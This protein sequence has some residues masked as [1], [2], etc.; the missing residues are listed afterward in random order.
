MRWPAIEFKDFVTLQ[1]GHD[2]TKSEMKHGDVPVLGSNCIIGYHEESKVMPPGVVTGRSGTLGVVQFVN[3]PY[4]PH[5]TALWVKNFKGNCPKFVYYKL[6]TLHLENFNGGASVPTLNRNVLDNIPI[7]VPDTKTQERIADIL[8]VYD[9]LIENN[10]RRMALLEEAAKQLYREWFVR[11][12]FPGYEHTY[13]TKGVPEGWELRPLARCARLLSGGTR[14]KARAVVWEGDIP[15]VSSG[16]LTAVRIHRTTLAVTAEAVEAGSR[17]VPPET[18]LAVVRGMSL[19]KEFRIGLTS[20][21]MSFNQDLKA[22]VP[23]PDIDVLLLYYSLDAQREQI[24]D[25]ASEAS[26]G[27]KKLDSAV[28]SEVPILKPSETIQ[29]LFRDDVALLHAQW[30]NLEEQNHRL[31]NVRNLLLPRLMNGEIAV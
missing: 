15:W 30:D 18:I 2:L 12:R 3:K 20:A 7:H 11:R 27:T 8:S 31:R 1:R 17:M 10:L 23:E 22:I 24:R 25:R 16:E 28:L 5:N 6:Q 14:S 19:A 9:G 13:V 29:R 21:P 4:W 26:H